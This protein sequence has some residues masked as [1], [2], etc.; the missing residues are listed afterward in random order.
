MISF[1]F[2]CISMSWCA[3]H[4]HYGRAIVSRERTNAALPCFTFSLLKKHT[5]TNENVPTAVGY[6]DEEENVCGEFTFTRL[7]SC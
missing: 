5:G 2:V 6:R 7:L 1:F 3:L 4:L